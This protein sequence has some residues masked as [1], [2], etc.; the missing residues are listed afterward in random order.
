[1][2]DEENN[3][4]W[5]NMKG[6]RAFA[7]FLSVIGLILKVHGCDMQ[8][9]LVFFLWKHRQQLKNSPLNFLQSG[10]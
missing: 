3:T 4:I 6:L 9:P 5:N 2:S 10:L 7:I 8:A 1:M